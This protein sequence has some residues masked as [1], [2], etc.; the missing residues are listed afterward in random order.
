VVYGTSYRSI[1]FS[2]NLT[3]RQAHQEN[4]EA[5]YLQDEFHFARQTSLFAGLRLDQNSLYGTEFTPRLSLI[6]H[7]PHRQSLRLSY[8]TSFRAPSLDESYEDVSLSIAPGVNSTLLGNTHL[9]PEEMVSY[10]TGYR[11]EFRNGFWGINAF[12]NRVSQLIVL[13]PTGFL[14]SPP[15]TPYT[16][17]SV[18]NVN[19]GTATMG[20]F[21]IEGDLALGKRLRLLANYAYQDVSTPTGYALGILAPKHKINLALRANLS[22]RIEAFLGAHFVGAS[23]LSSSGGGATVPAYVRVDAR[24]G[25]RFG[26]R[27]R[28]W[29]VAVSAANLLNDGHIEYPIVT[30]PGTPAQVAPQHRTVYLSITGKL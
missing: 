23:T 1:D 21:E 2:S 15:Y 10:E 12:Y 6:H 14:P 7:L 22:Q 27:N 26:T 4:L 30:A 24:F 9:V 29:T 19:A 28:P 20:G 18:E 13:E 3:G 16:P 17:S 25:Y 5:I 8:G 11:K